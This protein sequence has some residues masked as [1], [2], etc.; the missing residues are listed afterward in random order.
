M[1]ISEVLAFFENKN[2]NDKFEY[3]TGFFNPPSSDAQ[4]EKCKKSV[5]EQF[6]LVLNDE[7]IHLLKMSNGLSYNGFNIYGCEQQVEPYF[8]DGIVDANVEFWGEESLRK[9]LAYSEESTTR[10]VYDIEENKFLVVDRVTWDELKSFD[11]FADALMFNIEDC[12]I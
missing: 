3:G 6:G 2:T 12:C 1:K 10:L 8:L 7:Y 4:V 11:T 9:Y 5:F